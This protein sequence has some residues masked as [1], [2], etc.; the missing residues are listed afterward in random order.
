MGR[1]RRRNRSRP[2]ERRRYSSPKPKWR[3]WQ[4]RWTQNPVE[5]ELRVGSIPTFGIREGRN[6]HRRGRLPRPQ[7]RHPRRGPALVLARERRGRDPRGLARARRRQVRAARA[8]RD[9]RAAA[10]RRH[11]AR[12]LTHEP[13][14]DRGRR[15]GRA[16][17]LPAGG[18]RRARRDRRRRH[19]GSRRAIERRARLPGRGCA[20]DDRQ[21][22]LRD[23]LH[24][25]LRHRGLHLHRG[26]RPAPHHRRVAQPRD[27]RRGD[28]PSHRA[29]SP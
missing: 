18:P 27:G 22:P 15:R 7:C 5:R 6:A 19:P 24:L 9:L 13:V 8:T 23:R 25:R 21:R 17:E 29:G 14:Q 1:H 3:N 16:R 28:G 20:E 10:P 12:H 2:T 26:D 4:T 11:R